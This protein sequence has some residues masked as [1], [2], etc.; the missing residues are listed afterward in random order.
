M[1]MLGWIAATFVVLAGVYEGARRMFLDAHALGRRAWRW[2]A[3]KLTDLADRRRA[4]DQQARTDLR[5]AGIPRFIG[6]PPQQ[7]NP[8]ESRIPHWVG[9][10]SRSQT[11]MRQG[12]SIKNSQ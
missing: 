12:T 5:D 4:A 1:H 11:N 7:G 6:L 10:P 9:L 3:G 2:T 8:A